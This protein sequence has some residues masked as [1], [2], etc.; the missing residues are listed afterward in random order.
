[1]KIG[2]ERAGL[3]LAAGL[4]LV[5][6][7]AGIDLWAP[8]EPRY[9]QVAEEMRALERGAQDLVLPRLNGVPYDQ[10]P[11]LYF[12]LAAAFGAPGGHVGEW[13]ARLPSALAGIACVLLTAA[14]GRRLFADPRAALYGALLLLTTFRFAHTARR[15]QLDVLLTLFE[16]LAL[17]AYW[18]WRTRGADDLRG[19]RLDLA[20][21]HGATGLALLTKGPVGALPLLVI[22]L[23]H[24]W[25]RFARTAGEAPLKAGSTSAPRSPA[26]P[27]SPLPLWGIALS[28]AP[29]LLW[30]AA[31]SQLAPAGFFETAV[32][33]NVGHRFFSGTAH[34]RPFYYYLYQFPLDFLP[35][36]LLWPL[37]AVHAWRA[38][39]EP[40]EAASA[41]R[42]LW[43]WLAV[44]LFVFSL[45]AGKRGLYLLPAFPAAALLCG[46]SLSWAAARLPGAWLARAPVLGF[47]LVGAAG[48]ALA[49]A[50]GLEFASAPGFGI[51]AHFGRDVAWI[52][53]LALILHASAGWRGGD[54]PRRRVVVMILFVWMIELTAFA[55]LY[56]AFDA[57]K[58]PRPIAELAAQLCDE[59]ESI[60]VYDE[61]ALAG[62][63]AYYAKRSTVALQ[64]PEALRPFVARGGRIIIVKPKHMFTL[65]QEITFVIRSEARQ[66][67]RKL[68][69][70]EAF[71]ESG[72]TDL[73][74]VP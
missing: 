49:V 23:H 60:A 29:A 38:Q 13:S 66:G 71:S 9:A 15:A 32:L 6:A 24:L 28:V 11:P 20:L 37:V 51:P 21:L 31:A 39:P 25:E 64:N 1:M 5:T 42:L 54:R 17:L 26:P 59:H 53:L 4:L 48:L 8:D 56:P 62:G 58:S 52:A 19:R 7:L 14:L 12:W 70:I 65:M 68:L 61:R 63:V 47:V 41:R 36:T 67:D 46:H 40:G 35:W 10:K 55:A 57:E 16:G 43:L 74:L 73:D 3:A 30:L 44:F 18:R 69:I 34:I 72:D 50:R 22:A 33:D 2:A 45:S 27:A